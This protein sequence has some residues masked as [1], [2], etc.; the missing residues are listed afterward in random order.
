MTSSWSCKSVPG[1]PL[2]TRDLG[3][4][5]L[6]TGSIRFSLNRQRM[7]RDARLT[8]NGRPEWMP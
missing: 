1:M 6:S 5:R 8:D 2:R 4:V 3:I 7:S